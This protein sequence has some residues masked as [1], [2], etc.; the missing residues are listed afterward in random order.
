MYV[1]RPPVPNA[2][3]KSVIVIEDGDND[4]DAVIEMARDNETTNRDGDGDEIFWLV[5][6]KEPRTLRDFTER[7]LRA[8]LRPKVTQPKNEEVAKEIAQGNIGVLMA[9]MSMFTKHGPDKVARFTTLV[10]E[11]G[12]KMWDRFRAWQRA[13]PTRADTGFGEFFESILA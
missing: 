2:P 6:A 9:M 11:R 1:D 5:F 12:S 10:P 13:D 8:S 4:A 3:V 7:S